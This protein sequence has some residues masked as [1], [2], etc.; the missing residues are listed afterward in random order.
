MESTSTRLRCFVCFASTGVNARGTM[1][2]ISRLHRTWSVPREVTARNFSKLQVVQNSSRLPDCATAAHCGGN[3]RSRDPVHKVDMTGPRS[4]HDSVA[5]SLLRGFRR[6][7]SHSSDENTGFDAAGIRFLTRAHDNRR[8]EKS[9][10]GK[11]LLLILLADALFLL[12]FANC[13]PVMAA[14]QQSM[15]CCASMPCTPANRSQG[16][17]KNMTAGRKPIILPAAHG[18]LSAPTIATTVYP[19]A[20]DIIW[21]TSS[22]FCSMFEAQQHSPP[23]LYTLH[24]SLLI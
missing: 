5:L 8:V 15:K 7:R 4:A 14:N 10:M 22:P 16:C 2:R 19:K 11:K 12:Q 20:V 23:E 13:M 6:P 18:S 3:L 9:M 21:W 17:C 24:A 1:L